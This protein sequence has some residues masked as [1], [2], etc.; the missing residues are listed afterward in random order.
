MTQICICHAITFINP[1]LIK[2]F[3]KGISRELRMVILEAL[4]YSRSHFGKGIIIT[5]LIRKD[6][7]DSVHYYGMGGDLRSRCYASDQLLELRTYINLHYPY[8][9]AGK[10][11]C[12]IHDVGQ[13]IHIHLQV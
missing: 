5:S 1:K 3:D 10:Q 13:G 4:W 12:M 11:T 2:E 7:K 6:N 9:T 8:R